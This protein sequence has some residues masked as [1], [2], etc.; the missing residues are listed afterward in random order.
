[1]KQGFGD[2]KFGKPVPVDKYPAVLGLV[3]RLPSW[4]EN[5]SLAFI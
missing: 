4:Q 2:I 3:N 1:M 5:F